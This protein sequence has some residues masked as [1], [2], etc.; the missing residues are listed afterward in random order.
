M[1]NDNLGLMKRIPEKFFLSKDVLTQR[2]QIEELRALRE[3]NRYEPF[4]Q[5][6][7]AKRNIAK[8]PKNVKKAKESALAK[9]VAQ[10]SPEELANIAS[11]LGAKTN[12]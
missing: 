10:M 8:Q 6:K 9:L 11:A 12:G 2:K 4:K 5:T 3:K 1:F 7:S